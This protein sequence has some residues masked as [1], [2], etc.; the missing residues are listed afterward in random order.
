MEPFKEF[1][2][3]PVEDYLSGKISPVFYGSAVNNFGVREPLDC[4]V[5]DSTYAIGEN[6]KKE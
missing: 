2:C 3:F 5:G 4:F 1:I 6:W